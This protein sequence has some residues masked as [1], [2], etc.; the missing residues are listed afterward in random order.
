MKFGYSFNSLAFFWVQGFKRK[1]K[2]IE[3]PRSLDFAP[4]QS[5]AQ[6]WRCQFLHLPFAAIAKVNAL[7]RLAV[8]V[9][10]DFTRTHKWGGIYAPWL[11]NWS[12]LCLDFRPSDQGQVTQIVL[13][14][15]M[16][17]W[18]FPKVR[19]ESGFHFGP[20]GQILP[21]KASQGPRPC[22]TAFR[23]RGGKVAIWGTLIF[24]ETF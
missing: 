23:I 22:N 19:S 13:V 4:E 10:L 24:R 12:I 14:T 17:H 7:G 3:S 1:Q 18:P 2:W 20:I 15:F 11:Y 6:V 5:V 16:I 8:C 9:P 21:A